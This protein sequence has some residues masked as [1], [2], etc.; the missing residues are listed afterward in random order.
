MRKVVLRIHLI[1][2]LVLGLFIVTTCTTGSLIMVE[3]E[4]ESWMYPIGQSP[5][6]GDVGVAEIQKHADALNPAFKT[7]WI[8][9]TKTD[10]FYHVH[11]SKEGKDGRLIYA[12]P[13]TGEAFGKVLEERKEPFATIYNLH[14]YFLLTSVIGKAN[15][16]S[17]VGYLGIGL[18]LILLSG[19]YLWWPGIR[20]MASGFKIISNRSKL[21]HNMSLHKVIGIISIPV[22]LFAALTGVVNAFEKSIPTIVGFKAKEEIPASA[23]QSKSKDGTPLPVNRVVDLI[24]QAYPSSKLIKITFPQ[25]PGQSYQIGLKEGL[26]ASSGSNSTVYMDASNGSVLYKTNPHLIINLYNTWRKGLH[27]ATW[28]GETTKLIAFVF[29]MMPLFLMITGIVIWQLK[30]RGRKRNKKQQTAATVAA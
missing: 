14:R 6:P 16:A 3:P 8:D 29:G 24:N 13:G 20:R 30:A 21:L 7:D 17:V 23:L 27:F 11:L 15:A 28:G 25:K 4:V 2:S 12:D 10:G 22:L 19:A 18:I 1:L 9:M 26:G 5:T